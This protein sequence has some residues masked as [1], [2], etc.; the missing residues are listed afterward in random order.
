M[1]ELFELIETNLLRDVFPLQIPGSFTLATSIAALTH[2]GI[3]ARLSIASA[4]S[5]WFWLL[6]RT[7]VS[8]GSKASQNSRL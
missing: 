4:K 1:T 6:G 7:V 2:H 5:F 8:H 3:L